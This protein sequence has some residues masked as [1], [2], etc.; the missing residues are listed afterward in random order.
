MDFGK[1]IDIYLPEYKIGIEYNGTFWHKDKNNSDRR[2][3]DFFA[4]KSI[5]IVTIAEGNQNIVSGDTIEYV[6]N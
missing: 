6:Y 1:E 2:K 3:V 4:D 5:R